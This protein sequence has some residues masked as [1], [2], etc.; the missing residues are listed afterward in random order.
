MYIHDLS[1][2]A[3]NLG[4][5]SIKWYSLAYILGLVF[6]G[7]YIFM[8]NKRMQ[9]VKDLDKKSIED[10]MFRGMIG[11]LIGGRLAY[12]VFYNPA[13]Y[14]DNFHKI[15]F[16]WE[17]G[18][19]FHGGITGS[20]LAVLYH[21]KKTK[22]AFLSYMDLVACASPIGL[23]FGRIANF[24][25]GELYGKATNVAWGVVFPNAGD[26]ARHPSQLYE[27]FGEG[28]LALLLLYI[29]SYSKFFQNKRG[30]LSGLFLVIYAIVRILVE[31]VRIPDAQL[32][33][34]LDFITMGQILTLP[35]LLLGLYLIF[36]R[37]NAEKL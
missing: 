5:I 10:L 16:L 1:P 9:L 13:Y 28:L 2:I 24:I 17:G 12:V 26:F 30:S 29:A 34:F 7:I 27:A 15:F 21:S 3:L 25:N 18:M 11:M 19:S 6:V 32:G 35:M 20:V 23:L 31:F 33:Y 8:L 22:T 14:V 36:I 37:K 4:F